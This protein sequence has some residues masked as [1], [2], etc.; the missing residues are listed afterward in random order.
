MTV[1]A[2]AWVVGVP[3][4]V[5]LWEGIKRAG[6][7]LL[8]GVGHALAGTRLTR[9]RALRA[10]RAGIAARHARLPVLFAPDSGLDAAAVSVPSQA[11][12]NGETEPR[13]AADLVRSVHRAVVLGRPGSGKTTLLRQSMLA[14]AKNPAGRSAAPTPVLL[15]LGRCA[16]SALSLEQHIADQLA[17]DGFRRP[18]R[19][20]RRALADG[21]LALLFDGLDAVPSDERWR[22]VGELRAFAARHASCQIVV[23][24]RTAT[25]HGQLLPEFATTIHI[26]DLGDRRIRRFLSQWPGARGVDGLLAALRAAPRIM[27]LA[28]NPL[29][30]TM[31]AYLYGGANDPRTVLPRSRADFYREATDLLLGRLTDHR[32]V[33]R[34]AVKKAVMSRLAVLAQGKS[35]DRGLPR[36]DVLAEIAAVAAEVDLDPAAAGAVLDEIVDHSGLLLRGDGGDRYVFADLSL[37]EYLAAI[38]FEHDSAGLLDRY[39]A[40]PDGW[41]E[42]VK[43]WCAAVST[44]SGS[45]I[46]AVFDSDPVLAFECLADARVVADE[47]ADAVTGLVLDHF[48][49]RLLADDADVAAIVFA[50]GIVAADPRPRG[51]AVFEFLAAEARSGHPRVLAALAAT[52]SPRAAEILAGSLSAPAARSALAAMG[53]AAVP[54]LAA[55]RARVD[56]AAVDLLGAIGTPAAAVVLAER[57]W[58]HDLGATRAAWHLA[59]L[60][61]DAEIEAA[62]GELVVPEALASHQ[63]VWAPFRGRSSVAVARIAAQVAMLVERAHPASIPAAIDRVDARLAVPLLALGFGAGFQSLVRGLPSVVTRGLSWRNGDEQGRLPGWERVAEPW[64]TDAAIGESFVRRGWETQRRLYLA[65]DRGLRLALAARLWSAEPVRARDWAE[66]H[67]AAV[68]DFSSTS[69]LAWSNTVATVAALVAAIA[70]GAVLA[71]SGGW[72][73]WF[74]W[75][76]LLGSVGYLAF[77]AAAPRWNK[78]NHVNELAQ[79]LLSSLVLRLV[80]VTMRNGGVRGWADVALVCIVLSGY[81][82]TTVVL[83]ASGVSYLGWPVALGVVAALNAV[84]VVVFVR[85]ERHRRSALN[86]LRDLLERGLPEPG[87]PPAR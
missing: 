71:G 86:P 76:Y 4:L 62:L 78:R 81:A 8:R 9:G 1:N 63:W 16:G 33:F 77:V 7:W 20:A 21:A 3:L 28:R 24:S 68:G 54:A 29:L 87:Y 27:A 67:R 56:P 11:T 43:L 50:F 38:A 60:L 10:Y 31:I 58:D 35:A 12:E 83:L 70:G 52:N 34:G 26:A 19:F 47:V 66:V 37:R 65:T 15:D 51:K 49:R 40:D 13:D 18:D 14:W 6:P 59:G 2:W 36:A 41:R 64:E 44:D 57:I 45:L 22:V 17:R 53:D 84:A 73:P 46:E 75:P 32:T 85:G 25:Y 72:H 80:L 48:K 42:V 39:R 61:G 69:A 55:P 23:T 30:L 74:A 5:L 82:N 79:H